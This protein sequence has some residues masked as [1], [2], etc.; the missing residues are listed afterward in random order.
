M[1]VVES[2]AQTPAFGEL[3]QHRRELTAHCYRMLGSPFEA[4]DAVKKTLLRAGRTSTASRVAPRFVPGS[5]R[6]R[7][8]SASTSSK[9]ASGGRGRWIWG[10]RVSR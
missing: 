8:S 6:S 10:R 1:A 5:T 9:A 7:P 4:K 3:E 2:V